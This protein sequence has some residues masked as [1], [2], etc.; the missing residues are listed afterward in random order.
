M[1]GQYV[2]IDHVQK[3][4]LR[5]CADV[6]ET[7]PRVRSNKLWSSDTKLTEQLRGDVFLPHCSGSDLL[8]TDQLC[9]IL[10]SCLTPST[11]DVLFLFLLP[12]SGNLLSGLCPKRTKSPV[13]IIPIFNV[14]TVIDLSPADPNTC[15]STLFH[16]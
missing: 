7:C 1:C 8:Q 14:N 16:C 9:Q 10:I 3:S 11:A 12:F 4:K 13:C 2:I 6:M 5:F 15:S